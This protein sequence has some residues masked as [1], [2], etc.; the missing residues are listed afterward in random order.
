MLP[1]NPAFSD[2]LRPP[3]LQTAVLSDIAA[4]LRANIARGFLESEE[5]FRQFADALHDVVLLTDVSGT[6][7]YFVNLA[8]EEVWG[9]PRADLYADARALLDGVLV[10]DR[11]RVREAILSPP[12]EE[13]DL[14]FRIVRPDGEQRWAWRRAFPVVNAAGEIDRIASITEDIT[15][16]KRVTESHQRLIRGFTHDVKNPLGAANGYMALLEER[17]FGDLTDKQAE[18]VAR[19]RHS[20]GVALH[21]LT[22]LLDIERT[23]AG[24]VTLECRPVNV[25]FMTRE[26]LDAFRADA[27]AKQLT[28]TLQLPLN[29]TALM[30]ESDP[31]RLRQ[32][33]ANI[34]SNATKYT[35]V[36]GQI[37]V[38][39]MEA[40][41]GEGPSPGP[42]VALA[43]EDNGPGIP[44][45]KQNLIFREFTRFQPD[46]AAGTGIGLAISQ[47]LAHALGGMITFRSTPG[48]G[49]TFTIWVPHH[50]AK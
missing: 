18:Y 19:A 9:R 13:H 21:L 50:A 47:R 48:S 20:I 37:S 1:A 16:R 45:E 34:V 43:V 27:G 36:G 42:W 24:E 4:A 5:H 46:A 2:E 14:E 44:F 39:V 3:S 32:I 28:F 12:L 40:A 6:K 31:E 35:Q 7:A 22:Q 30:I 49:S 11:D 33:L 38:R 8:Y 29:D 25:G 23:E 26:I 41:D 10:E 17:V 15:D